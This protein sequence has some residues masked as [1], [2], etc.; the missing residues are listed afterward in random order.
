MS[1]EIKAA[2]TVGDISVEA[3]R[4]AGQLKWYEYAS[5]IFNGKRIL[6][7]GCGL[8]KGLEILRRSNPVVIGQDLDERLARDQVLIGPLDR[9]E[10]KTFDVVTSMD[11]IEHVEDDRGFAANLCRIAKETVFVTTP[12]WTISRCKW[13]YHLREYT[14]RELEALFKPY[15]SVQLLKG[16]SDGSMIFPV[17]HSGRYHAANALRSFL[18]TAFVT[19]VINHFLPQRHRI[20]GHNAIL[21][22]ISN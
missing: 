19:R 21:V 12:N 7:A 18:P 17:V 14:P 15:G 4:G 22:S 1:R 10:S 2:R 5:Q 6:D 20:L 13:P 8:G 11:V 9:I 3:G 16:N